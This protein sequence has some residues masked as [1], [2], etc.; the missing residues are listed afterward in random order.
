MNQDRL[1][2]LLTFHEQDPGDAF[3]Q[4]AIAQEYRK[5]GQDKEA[6]AFL[7][8]LVVDQPQYT[9]TYYHLGKLYEET[10]RTDEAVATYQKGVAVAQAQ[11]NFKD[12]SELQ[13]ALLHA[14]GVD[15]DDEV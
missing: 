10:G 5:R 12:L 3:T 8:R 11:R 14:Q 1:A 2:M 4:F 13:D 9:G 7:E 15:F 6:L